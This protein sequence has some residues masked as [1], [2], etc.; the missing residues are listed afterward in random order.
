MTTGIRFFSYALKDCMGTVASSAGT[1]KY[2]PDWEGENVGCRVDNGSTLAP[3]YMHN[4]GHWLYDTLDT[5]CEK[6]YGYNLSGCKGQSTVDY[7][8]SEKWYIE[9][10]TGKCVQDCTTQ[11][12]TKCGGL[13]DS[14]NLKYDTQ[15]K[16]CAERSWWDKKECMA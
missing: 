12:G 4:S 1:G 13:A 3:E 6:H 9:W 8:G 11:S 15:E 7:T 2:F 16:C 5:C 10:S 14:W